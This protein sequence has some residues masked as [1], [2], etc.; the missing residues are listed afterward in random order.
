MKLRQEE[1]VAFIS[2]NPDATSADVTK[3]FDVS[4]PYASTRLKQMLDAK[5]VYVSRKSRSL[6][7]RT[8]LHY[9]V[10]AVEPGAEKPERAAAAAAQAQTTT[11]GTTPHVQR[12]PTVENTLV[13]P[14]PATLS[15]DLTEI[16]RTLANTL[17]DSLVSHVVAAV[18]ADLAIKLAASLPNIKLP[19][20]PA[21]ASEQH[22]Y[23]DAVVVAGTAAPSKPV[24][25]TVRKPKIGIVGLLPQQKVIIDKEFSNDIDLRYWKD[26]SN[27]SLKS[28]GIACAT[29][30]V[31]KWASHS[32]METLKSVGANC[33]FLPGGMEQLRDALTDAYVELAK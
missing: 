12:T 7:N 15:L 21:P 24:V 25:S 14:L 31:T 28:L 33:R 17:V 5:R 1:L 26:E 19:E 2:A 13:K 3:Q 27:A 18:H 30:F 11:V 10:V 22:T 16:V 23:D 20:L 4:Q 6:S 29:T 32:Q 8:R 9:R